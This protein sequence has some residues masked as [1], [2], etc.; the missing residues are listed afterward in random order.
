[1]SPEPPA[2][3]ASGPSRP[4]GEQSG[5]ADDHD[6][7]D[8]LAAYLDEMFVDAPQ[9]ATFHG[10]PGLDAESPDL[11]ADAIAGREQRD[12]AWLARF[13][14]YGDDVLAAE[15]RTDRDLVIAV[16]RGR[17]VLRDW[18]PWRRRP[19]HYLNPALMGVF[20]LFLRQPLP[21]PELV[22]A[23]VARLSAVPELLAAGRA[24]L[25]AGLVPRVLAERGL[26]MCRAGATYARELVPREVDEPDARARLAEAGAVAG[27]AF[28]GFA[29]HLESLLDGAGEDW[30]IG[31]SRYTA[32]LHEAELLADDA[33]RLH[34][35][36]RAAWAEIEAEMTAIAR[37]IDPLTPD[38][39]A[40]VRSCGDDRPATPEAMRL[41]YERETARARHF[42]IDH[43]LVT[44]PEGER[45]EVVPS[46][47]FQRPV[48]A[49]ASYFAPPAFSSSL[50]GRF[51]VPYPPDGAPPDEVTARLSDNGHHAI[52]T[53]TAHEAYPGHHWH[54]TTMARARPV[55]RVHRSPYFTE[56]WALYAEQVM[57]EH[58]YFTDA[59]AELMH[60]SF[61][62]FRAARIVVDTGLHAG[63]MT[64]DEAVG[65]LVDHVGLT[66]P[67][68]RTEVARY[69]ATPTQAAAYLTG[70]LEIGRLRDRWVAEGRGDLPGFHD[71]LAATGALPVALAERAALP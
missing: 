15:Q 18:Q 21:D 60:L 56:G 31:E 39:L 43:R 11:S 69:C 7:D 46:P 52:P 4:T 27:E 38:W 3:P 34:E 32:L 2:R 53:I 8:Q 33:T 45:C 55:R 57:R 28:D 26:G 37:A 29:S 6:L 14:G 68:A 24:N 22:A 19:E 49:V 12:D 1:M 61:R 30:A 17:A 64:R 23:A 36:G 65:H 5:G 10:R 54:L 25:D 40:A 9:L 66:E 58:G 48:M 63:D 16:L 67:V 62:L 70:C 42:L 35:R 50:L 41:A 59:R 47:P 20:S 51:N 44:L 71:T 13:A